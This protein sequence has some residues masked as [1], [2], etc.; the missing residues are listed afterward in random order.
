[1]NDPDAVLTHLEQLVD[2]GIGLALGG[3]GAG[4][5]ALGLLRALPVRTLTLDRLFVAG[6]A[7]PGS[8]EAI[9]L[10]SIASLG[11]ALRMTVGATGVDTV[12]ELVAVRAAGC[13][14]AQGIAVGPMSPT[15]TW[16]QPVTLDA[17]EG[18]SE[19]TGG[20]V[21]DLAH[22]LARRQ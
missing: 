11:R 21:V 2:E 20:T 22:R 6:A 5:S 19:D 7:V 17:G 10:A 18:D 9:M 15:A 8:R 3:F 4:F 1:M 12:P 16:L 13:T 14:H